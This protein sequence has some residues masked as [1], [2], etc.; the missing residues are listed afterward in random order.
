M[1]RIYQEW[2]FWSGLALFLW[3]A[4]MPWFVQ[5]SAGDF[6]SIKVVKTSPT[7]AEEI[8]VLKDLAITIQF[9]Q[10][11]DPTMQQD[12]LMDQRG[13]TDEQGNPIEIQGDLS[14][15]DPKTLQ[16]KP[17]TALK[18]K[19]TY[20]ISLYSLRSKEGE[21]MDQAPFR[22]VFTTGSEQ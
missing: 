22:L 7:N 13:A 5:T 2:S 19:S 3:M 20:Q 8:N 15:P 18:P 16:F 11:M 4:L 9:N 12:F 14:W 6:A 17:K 1:R 10:D 21:T